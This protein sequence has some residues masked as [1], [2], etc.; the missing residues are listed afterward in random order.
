MTGCMARSRSLWQSYDTPQRRC[1]I[2]R[3][4]NSDIRSLMCMGVTQQ[5]CK[6]SQLLTMMLFDNGTRSFVKLLCNYKWISTSESVRVYA[7]Y[8]PCCL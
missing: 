7:V 6:A 5:T 1:S 8:G 2:L 3:W 4:F